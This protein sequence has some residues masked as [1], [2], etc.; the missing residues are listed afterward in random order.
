[1]RRA[2][3]V[4]AALLSL[5][6]GCSAP[7]SVGEYVGD[8]ARDLVDCFRV[9][10]GYGGGL[11]ARIHTVLL[12]PIGI[13]AAS[14]K[15][16]G[17][18]GPGGAGAFYWGEG[19]ASLFLFPLAW[20]EIDVR[21]PDLDIVKELQ[22]GKRPDMRNF[23]FVAKQMAHGL[24]LG[25]A[26]DET[27]YRRTIS[28]GTQAADRFWL[29]ADVTLIIPSARAG[30]NPAE[31]LDF[32]LGLFGL[33]ILGDDHWVAETDQA[34]EII[35]AAA[36]GDVEKVKALL[37]DNSRLVYARNRAH[38]TPLYIAAEHGHADVVE[39]L[40]ANGAH[41]HARLKKKPETPLHAAARGGNKG[42]FAAVLLRGG[43]L[44]TPGLLPAAAAGGNVDI[45]KQVFPLAAEKERPDAL[46]AAVTRGGV[47][48]VKLLVARGVDLKARSKPY[49]MGF[50]RG[51]LLH[52]A[53]ATAQKDM[54][55]F[56]VDQGLDVNARD[57]H[58]VT[59]LERDLGSENERLKRAATSRLKRLARTKGP[60]YYH[61]VLN[62]A[63]VHHNTPLHLAA[64]AGYTG[65][66]RLLFTKGAAINARNNLG[67]TALYCAIG[68]GRRR[69]ARV[70]LAS[71]ADPKLADATGRTPLHLAAPLGLT[72][73]VKLL[74]ERGAD[75]NARENRLS[76]TPLHLASERGLENV[77]AL[78]LEG[79]ADVNVKDSRA[80][81]PLRIGIEKGYPGLVKLLLKYHP[82][83]N[84]QGR[85]GTPL[86]LAARTEKLA[87]AKLLLDAG[88]KVNTKGGSKQ[89]TPL[90][91]AAVAGNKKMVEL[92]LARGADPSL[93][94]K[95][96]RTP[97][98]E[99][100]KAKHS[101]IVGVLE[102]HAKK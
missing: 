35:D 101:A 70:L 78:L 40:F 56:L 98:D 100:R 12:P 99:A 64:G 85:G 50:T 19:S 1:M 87:I 23:R 11:H 16:F 96:G 4:L 76:S 7:R 15:K 28:K 34:R 5:A 58:I 18:D 47:A 38:A 80:R 8:R 48:A 6:A 55:E 24:L 25:E 94:S 84:R 90:H 49:D 71:G 9:S 59:P 17:W 74:L 31:I 27:T 41:A 82:D 67:R 22:R 93:T 32:A 20:I 63:Y 37:D 97:L 66:V 62:R 91:I 72:E 13:G 10:I 88:A 26:V 36:E 57:E 69:T 95:Q 60:Y 65:T 2:A 14:A 68:T 43:D 30:V 33:D 83:V 52:A 75:P 89:E 81:T 73:T 45:L 77:A 29:G 79:G 42:V 44:K 61:R 39:A 92:F 46:R 3:L 102:R 21:T 51:T 53:A 54:V 86:H